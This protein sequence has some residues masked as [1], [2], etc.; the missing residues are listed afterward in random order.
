MLLPDIN[1]WIPLA[2]DDHVH[3]RE[4]YLAAFAMT[5]NLQLVTF[6]KGFS[7]FAGLTCTIL[8]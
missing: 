4:A 7:R 3:H 2:F 5:A 1:V 6:D 8:S